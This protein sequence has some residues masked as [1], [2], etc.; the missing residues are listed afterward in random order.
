MRLEIERACD[1]SKLLVVSD[2]G[3]ILRALP[4]PDEKAEFQ[5][6]GNEI[7]IPDI[8]GKPVV[9][10]TYDEPN[11]KVDWKFTLDPDTFDLKRI[12]QWR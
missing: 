7:G 9:I 11:A 6:L 4:P 3:K 10:V 5:Y 12:S 2:E 1:Q 8:D